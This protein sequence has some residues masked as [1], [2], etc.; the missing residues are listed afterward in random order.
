M[1]LDV[2][3]CRL[4][5]IMLYLLGLQSKNVLCEELNHLIAEANVVPFEKLLGVALGQ[6]DAEPR[7]LFESLC[8]PAVALSGNRILTDLLG[9][10]ELLLAHSLLSGLIPCMFD[11]LWFVVRPAACN[12]D[13]RFFILNHD[14]CWSK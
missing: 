14:W 1:G 13:D 10:R 2:R 3:E 12:L 8:L 5:L 6:I 7:E 9:E 11:V 4:Y